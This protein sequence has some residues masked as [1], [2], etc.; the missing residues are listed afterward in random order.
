VALHT[1]D[2]CL[3]SYEQLRKELGSKR[4]DLLEAY[5]FWRLMLDEAQMVA[6]SNSAAA[7]AASSIWRFQVGGAPSL[8][9]PLLLPQGWRGWAPVGA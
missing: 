7:A 1:C 6:S 4:G 2:V 9:L 8:L 5:G 3:M